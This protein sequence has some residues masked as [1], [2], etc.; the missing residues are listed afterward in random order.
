MSKYHSLLNIFLKL[1]YFRDYVK[2]ARKL[3]VIVK[4][5]TNFV[6]CPSFSSEYLHISTGESCNF[7]FEVSFVIHNGDAYCK[8]KETEFKRIFEIE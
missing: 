7:L 6:K 5:S 3:G 1:F 4:K 8:N 2:Y